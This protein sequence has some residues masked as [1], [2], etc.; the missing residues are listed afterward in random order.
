ML[1]KVQ[2]TM[3][4]LETRT[5]ELEGKLFDAEIA[6][7]NLNQSKLSLEEENKKNLKEK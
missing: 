6:V 3:N 4:S 2:G 1:E 7:E 5:T